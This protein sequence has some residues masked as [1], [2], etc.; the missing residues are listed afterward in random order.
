[1]RPTTDTDPPA[2]D[3]SQPSDPPQSDGSAA[4]FPAQAPD[5]G[6]SVDADGGAPSPPPLPPPPP[7]APR[8][9][10]DELPVRPVT[11]PRRLSKVW[12]VAGPVVAITLAAVT[13]AMSVQLPY[14][15]YRPG[16]ARAVEP[17][18][19]ITGA[20]A[21]KADDG[22]LFVTVGV[23]RPSGAQAL[24]GWL[25]GDTDVVPRNIATGGLSD[26]QNDTFN[27]QLMTSSKD[28]A[29][30]VALEK[31][32]YEVKSSANGAVVTQIDPSLP[33]AD[34]LSPGDTIVGIDGRP[35]TESSQV[36][37]AVQKHEPGDTVR[38]EIARLGEEGR[39]TVVAKTVADPKDKSKPL[40]GI[41]A[42][43]LP[44]FDF[45][46]KVD[47]DSGKV[48]GPSAGLAFTLSIIDRL[49]PG[50]LTNGKKVAV[51][52]TIELDGTVGPVGGVNQ[53]T[54]AAI[55]EGAELFIVPRDEYA[56][57][58]EMA[59]GRIRVAAV[60][61]LDDALKVLRTLGGD[62]GKVTTRPADSG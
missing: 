49:S 20:K 30:K 1:M 39:Q 18:I 62:A 34:V 45:P 38:I 57:A 24:A 33:V 59:D 6:S 53:K 5:H 58:K 13:V 46:V 2:D 11:T 36:R 48:G 14:Y 26:K 61:D 52:G 41:A 31:L 47:I 37:E 54:V 16:S 51:T 7:G 8:W 17:L 3:E 40:L 22:I 28:K 60:D 50:S 10:R 4:P 29:A 56:A 35:I 12:W 43:T 55:D 44:K 42:E 32:G 9:D 23:R 19:T 25:S 27:K 15:A 21:E